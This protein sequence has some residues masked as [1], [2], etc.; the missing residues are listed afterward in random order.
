MPVQARIVQSGLSAINAQAVQGTVASAVTATGGSQAAA[1]PLAADYNYVNG[2]ST[3]GVIIPAMNPG[4][5]ITVYNKNAGA[6]QVYPPTGAIINGLGANSPY[7]VAA[8][9]P[10]AVVACITPLIYIASQSA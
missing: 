10:F 6:I 3:L 9:T 7:A 2:G 1:F 4:D 5:E 8:A